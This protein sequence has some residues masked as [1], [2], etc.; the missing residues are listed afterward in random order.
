MNFIME[1]WGSWVGV[2]FCVLG[3]G[4]EQ[5]Q[6]FGVCQCGRCGWIVS[7][8]RSVQGLG[9][10]ASGHCGEGRCPVLGLVLVRARGAWLGVQGFRG[11]T[12]Q[13]VTESSCTHSLTP[14]QT[15]PAPNKT[16]PDW[17][18]WPVEGKA[19]GDSSTFWLG[20]T[21]VHPPA[22][23]PLRHNSGITPQGVELVTY[24][25]VV[26]GHPFNMAIRLGIETRKQANTAPNCL[27][28]PSHQ[29][30]PGSRL[31]PDL[32]HQKSRRPRGSRSAGRLTLEDSKHAANHR[33]PYL[34]D[35]PPQDNCQ[36]SMS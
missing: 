28:T 25:V 30:Y 34:V 31:S 3:V 7:C 6:V 1:V 14:N 19:F 5:G 15:P 2:C 9:V 12:F 20:I 22:N 32:P 16:P 4:W 29:I 17:H 21:T 18:K 8:T 23:L 35:H 13:A 24:A 27:P 36:D 11:W 10:W 26:S 33:P